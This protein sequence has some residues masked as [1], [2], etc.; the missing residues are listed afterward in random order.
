[1]LLSD[2]KVPIV[3]DS[4]IK[5]QKLIMDVQRHLND[6][7]F[8]AG[9]VDGIW[10]SQTAE[11]NR[12]FCKKYHLN[13]STT[14]LFGSTWASALIKAANTSRPVT[15]ETDVDLV[16]ISQPDEVTCQATCIAM[17][18]PQFTVAQIRQRL[19]SIG[20]PGSPLVM[21]SFLKEQLGNR[22]AYEN[23]AS[24]SEIRKWLQNGEYLIIHGW[25]TK[26]G[27]VIGLDGVT[28]G[29][30]SVKDPWSEFN[31]L[32]FAYTITSK[33]YDGYYSDLL[34]YATCVLGQSYTDA[35]QVY[36]TLAIDYGLKG[37]WVH[38]VLPV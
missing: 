26:S 27:H 35:R 14:L 25:F 31:A 5:D 9:K 8:N 19:E 33:F 28:Q 30:V 2:I 36:R 12:K 13:N 1:M 17:V 16:N 23:N 4:F 34:I 7:G 18:C 15:K 37:A 11:A 32:Q 3:F 20:D 6:A 38:R 22:Y 21:G 29:K 10:G 24:L